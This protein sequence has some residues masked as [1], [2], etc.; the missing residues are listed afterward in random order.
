MDEKLLKDIKF[1]RE[2]KDRALSFKDVPIP[3]EAP[4]TY[5]AQLWVLGVVNVLK[6]R[7]Y[8]ITKDQK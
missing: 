1:L 2:V 3:Y 5:Q 8:K 7:G 4:D 6:S